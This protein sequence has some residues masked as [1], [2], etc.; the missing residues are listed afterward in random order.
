MSQSGC[1][2]NVNFAWGPGD[3]SS[4]APCESLGDQDARTLAHELLGMT[5]EEF[6]AA[7]RGSP[8]SVPPAR[9]R[10][11]V[12]ASRRL[13]SRRVSPWLGSV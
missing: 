2:F 9:R 3:D 7:F 12:G 10:V 6:S 11:E 8:Y 5:Q 13:A 4:F 1:P